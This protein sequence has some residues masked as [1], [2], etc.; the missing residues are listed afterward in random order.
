MPYAVVIG[1]LAVLL[2]FFPLKVASLGT[3]D[4]VQYWSAWRLLA[5][6]QNPYDP[7]L[8]HQTQ[9]ALSSAQSSLI[10]SWNPPW[11]Y[12]LL[13]PFLLPPFIPGATLW[14]LFQVGALLF[15]G[16]N[17]A[18]ALK[19]QSLGLI[20]GVCVS[21]FFLPSLYAIYYGQLGILFALSCTTFL[22]A[23]N[24]TRYT[25]A[26]I[27]LLPLALK[28]H[29]FVLCVI[30]AVLWLTQVPRDHAKRFLVGAIGGFAVLLG[31]TVV[32]APSSLSWW[33][34]TIAAPSVS[35][36]GPHPLKKWMTHTSTT[37]LRLLIDE[38]LE[39]H[40]TWLLVPIPA[41][42]FVLT[43]IYFWVRKPRIDWNTLLPPMLCLCLATSSYAW[44]YDQPVLILC[45]YL[46][47]SRALTYRSTLT[48]YLILIGCI[49][50]Q[51]V[52]II[53]TTRQHWEGY[54]F[55]LMPW[56]LLILLMTA[57]VQRAPNQ[58]SDVH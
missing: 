30:P 54:W 31:T 51:L 27:S 5:Q 25:V 57:R 16:L 28:P 58:A 12:I 15:I 18:R 36:P 32:L 55:F 8:L 33:F 48:R 22:L 29:L 42:A 41:G 39:L 3:I 4:Y 40:P 20:G 7:T 23:L 13:A 50:T 24:A 37:A 43:L 10:Y 6:G 17:A 44:V 26:G 2:W 35:H 19:V 21:L 46:V 34:N 52:P 9:S 45:Q 1:G 53:L 38:K 14:C 49:L 11:T 56:A 47:L